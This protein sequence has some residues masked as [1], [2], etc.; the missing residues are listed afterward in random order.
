VRAQLAA[1]ASQQRADARSFQVVV[2]IL[3]VPSWA[4]RAPSGCEPSATTAS[5]RALRPQAIASYRALIGSLLSLARSEGVALDWWSPWNEPNDP[6][7][8]SPQRAACSPA[9]P[10]LAPVVYAQLARAMAAELAAAG[11]A[12]HLVLGE[13]KAVQADSADSTS[14]A[15]FVAA[16]PS[17]VVCLAGVWSIHDYAA[18]RAGPGAAPDA[19]TMLE[20]ALDARGGCARGAS[21]WVTEAGA[22]APHPGRPRP[23]G[24]ADELAGCVALAQ[25]LQRWYADLR[26]GAVFQYSFRE[27]PAYPVGLLSA[28]LS[29]VYPAYGLWLAYTRLRAAGVAPPTP[30]LGCA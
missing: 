20:Q 28:D 2:D 24:R 9:S 13:L 29:H 26:V 19:V 23:A 25:Q 30:A 14:V 17:D 7:F 22:G 27:D 12:H 21:V 16:L 10:P 15:S 3:A 18:Q 4:A 1:I 11:G 8:L 5:A 6:R